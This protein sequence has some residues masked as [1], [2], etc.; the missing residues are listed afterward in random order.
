M[1]ENKPYTKEQFVLRLQAN[2]EEHCGLKVSKTQ[3][4]E[5]FKATMNTA[6]DMGA[7][8]PP[9]PE[10]R[11]NTGLSLSGIG[12][13][14]VLVSGRSGNKKLRFRATAR[15]EK[16]L[17]EGRSFFDV[18]ED[19]RAKRAARAPRRGKAK[20]DGAVTGNSADI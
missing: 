7:E 18:D 19:A 1:E 10:R 8:A 15:A 5:L 12:S 9:D 20:V 11:R 3:T 14:Y 2:L 4:W 6:F 16:V 17:S 13:F